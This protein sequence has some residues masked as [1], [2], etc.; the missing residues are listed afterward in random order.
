LVD[1]QVYEDGA[2]TIVAVVGELDLA[3][4][5]RIRHAVTETLGPARPRAV[6]PQV[7]LD[8]GAVHFIDSSGLG[9]VLGV[10][11][12]V[13]LAGGRLRVVAAEPQVLDLLALLELDTIL[14]VF[15]TVAEATA[16]PAPP[17][18]DAD[19]AGAP[20]GVEAVGRG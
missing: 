9:V 17:A 5:P 12:R 20:T 18:G 19:D 15:A 11:R 10:L 3:V 6:T 13:R 2:W 1:V 7:V 16:T 4:A 14:D 8:L